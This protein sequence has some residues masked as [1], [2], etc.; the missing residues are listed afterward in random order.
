VTRRSRPVDTLPIAL[1]PRGLSRTIAAAYIGVSATLFDQMVSDGRMPNPMGDLAGL[2]PR[3]RY[4]HGASTFS[5]IIAH[6][7]GSSSGGS[8][9]AI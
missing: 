4:L 8:S 6:M 9:L 3:S 2:N 5:A 1:P 7:R